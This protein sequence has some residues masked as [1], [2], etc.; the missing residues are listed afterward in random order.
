MSSMRYLAEIDYA[1]EGVDKTLLVTS[2]A[3]FTTDDDESVRPWLAQP[4]LVRKDIIDENSTLGASRTAYGAAVCRNEHGGLDGFRT[5]AVDGRTYTAWCTDLDGAAFP[6]QWAKVF[7][8]TMVKADVSERDATFRLRDRQA[9]TR[10]RLSTQTYG[11]TNPLPGG[12]DGIPS[13]L[14]AK[15]LPVL[16]GWCLNITP[17]LVNSSLL[18]YQ[19]N[20]RA[21]RDVYH[22]YDGGGFLAKGADYADQADLEANQPARGEYRVWRAGGMFRI[23]S[24]PA[25][26]VTCDAIEG[27]WPH[28]RTAG[29]IWKR[30]LV[31]RAGIDPSL[32]SDADIALL[33]SVQ[34]AGLGMYYA[35]EV[36]PPYV[37]QALDD[38][39]HSVGCWWGTDKTGVFRLRRLE[40]PSGEPVYTFRPG[41]IVKGSLTPAEAEDENGLP[42]HQ[43]TVRGVPN[44]TV[45]TTG[46]LGQVS[47]ARRARLALPF[48]DA[49]DADAAVKTAHPFAPE[50]EIVTK[51]C[52][53][54]AVEAEAARQL[55][56][57]KVD[58]FRY[59]LVAGLTMALVAALDLGVVVALA[60]ERF[61]DP[62]ALYLVLGYELNPAEQTV[63]V[64]IWGGDEA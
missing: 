58:R 20:D 3:G 59:T 13:D 51:L 50:L 1:E 55:A 43:V 40:A 37:Q 30:L 11:G 47:I 8:G 62:P 9:F 35:S 12:V 16:Y 2:G 4:A 14:R 54:N 64:T 17:T 38:A 28:D 24:P 46:L 27:Q 61:A 45:Q 22:V 29:Q 7:T 42:V 57:R 6:S 10:Q 34:P 52:C 39:A 26:L 60:H 19:V 15:T 33:D 41:N 31:D 48:Q 44:Y 5:H 63:K 32:I 23:G 25:Q 21:I 36:T 49:M 53:L 56:L 18:I